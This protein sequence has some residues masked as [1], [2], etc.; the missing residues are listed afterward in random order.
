MIAGAITLTYP[1][2]AGLAVVWIIGLY[3]VLYGSM[4]IAFAF[5]TQAELVK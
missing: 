5:R 2:S 1:V 3:A 4:L